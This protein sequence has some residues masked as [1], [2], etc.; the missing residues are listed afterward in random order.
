MPTRRP[1]L[2]TFVIIGA[3][4]SATRWLRSN[5]GRHPEIFTA[6]Q[7]VKF[8]NHPKR[9]AALGVD[10]Y[11]A[12]FVGWDNEPI[13]GEATPGYMMLRHEPDAV[14]TRIAEVLPG[15]RLI[16]LLRNPVDR[17][18]SALL[19][20]IR[21]ER[22]HPDTRLIEFV[23]AGDPQQEWMGIVSG[24]MYASSLEPFARRF[25][26]RLLVL[27]HDRVAT[28]PVAVY[29][30]ALAHV[31]V[32]RSFVP[33]TADRPVD[34][35]DPDDAHVLSAAERLELYELYREDIAQVERMFGVDLSIW[36]PVLDTT[37]ERTGAG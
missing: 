34:R 30:R 33:E 23:R 12:Q 24:G 11:R 16:A 4:K 5:L 10:W 31:G 29:R 35:H 6:A 37:D 32:S 17:A 27:L 21:R 9:M 15:V 1:P 20:H 19:H 22:V 26:D 3:Q 2:P 14:A 28:D 7:E 25:G 8:F 36:R 18:N 13:L